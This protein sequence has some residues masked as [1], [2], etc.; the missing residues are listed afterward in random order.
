MLEFICQLN[1]SD[2][3]QLVAV[4]VVLIYTTFTILLWNQQRKQFAL[5]QRPWV[6]PTDISF[7]EF[8]SPPEL[9]VILHNLGKLPALCR[10]SIPRIRIKPLPDQENCVEL[11]ITEIARPLTVFPHTSGVDSMFMYLMHLTPEQGAPLVDGARLEMDIS[12]EYKTLTVDGAR[13]PFS[14]SAILE[15]HHFD[16]KAGKQ[17]TLI[18]NATAK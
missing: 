1:P 12:I 4:V 16:R 17:T 13:F 7:N 6:N 9:A 14:Y 11:E 18:R 10:I 2:W 3:I 8:T 5:A 15:V